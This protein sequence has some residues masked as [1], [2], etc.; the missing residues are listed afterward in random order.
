[1]KLWIERLG[2]LKLTVVLLLVVGVVL[3]IGT[4]FES[5]RGA[6]A[7]RAVY[8]APWF[9]ALE[10]LFGLNL[11]A[12]LITRWPRN[13]FRIGFA[14]THASMLLILV[15]AL[16]TVLFKVEGR[17]P[18]WEGQSTDVVFQGAKEGDLPP[19]TLPFKLRLDAFEIDT[20]PGTQR[21]AMFRSR[22]VVEKA[23][24]GELPGVIQMNQPLSH[25]GYT[26]FQSSYQ[27]QGGREMTILS[28]SKL[29]LIH[30]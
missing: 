7:A 8:Y 19:L 13:R 16:M 25:G 17:M 22:V 21:P 23:G 27:I 14:L 12:A 4:I 30:I 9:F 18:I 3:A 6:E 1:M 29:S 11:L 24:G 2:S 5:L 20:Y 10:G 26:F 15:G 28:V